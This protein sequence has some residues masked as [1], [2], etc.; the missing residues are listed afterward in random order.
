MR[1]F[2]V[3]A[4]Y[5]NS[6]P[7]LFTLVCEW[8]REDFVR[9]LCKGGMSARDKEKATSNGELWERWM[10]KTDSKDES[11]DELNDESEDE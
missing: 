4:F 7:S 2:V 10:D 6:H 8:L 1:D 3:E 11:E 9:E 5:I